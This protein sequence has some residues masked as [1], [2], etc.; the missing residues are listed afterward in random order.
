LKPHKAPFVDASLPHFVHD[1]MH[2]FVRDRGR[3]LA[4]AKLYRENV[5]NGIKSKNKKDRNQMRS[6]G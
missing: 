4:V 6:S 3:F 5:Y 1:E 2:K